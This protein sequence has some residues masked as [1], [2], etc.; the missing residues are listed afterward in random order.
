MLQTLLTI[1][2]FLDEEQMKWLLGNLKVKNCIL[3]VRNKKNVEGRIFT[4]E[5]LI[6]DEEGIWLGTIE[7]PQYI[8]K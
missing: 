2:D 1:R 7:K 3:L 4:Q 6:F 5:L 8:P